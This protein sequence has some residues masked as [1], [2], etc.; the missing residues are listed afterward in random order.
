LYAHQHGV[1]DNKQ[2]VSPKLIFI[3]QYLQKAGYETAMIGKWHMGGETDDP[4]RGFDH[5]V[6]FKAQGT[7]LPNP[8]GFNVD[9]K[10][11]PQKGLHHR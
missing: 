11:V 1:V 6:S 10:K 7:Y 8:N 3:S 9:G 5:W 2:S 4:Q